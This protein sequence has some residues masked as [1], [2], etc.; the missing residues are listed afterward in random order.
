MIF[1]GIQKTSTIDFPG[2]LACVLFTRGCDLD[3]F[4]CHNRSLISSKGEVLFPGFVE[5]FLQKRQGLLDGVVISGG[6]PTLQK[7]LPEFIRFVRSLDYRIKLDTNGGHPEIVKNLLEEGL[8]DYVAVDWKAPKKDCPVVCGRTDHY[9]NTMQT[10]ELLGD[11]PVAYEARTTLYPGLTI[12]GLLELMQALP[13]MPKYRLNYFK[14]PK[15]PRPGSEALIERHALTQGEI[16][17]ALPLLKAVQP[18][19]EWQ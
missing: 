12:A 7:D 2:Y 14:M 16:G 8:L 3:C 18:N 5:Q 4:Y 13:P 19:L 10:I 1:G 11:Y 15:T 9:E 6:E 17:K